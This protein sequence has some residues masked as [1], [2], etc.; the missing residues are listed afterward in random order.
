[1][2]NQQK[3]IASRTLISTVTSANS[4]KP[5]NR[6]KQGKLNKTKMLYPI[7]ILDKLGIKPGK[8]N[9]GGY[10]ILRCPYHKNGQEKKPSLHVHQI[11]G[12]FKCQSC[13]EKGDIIKLYMTLA[14]VTFCNAIRDLGAFWEVN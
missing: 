14:N 7:A 12:H 5:V 13:G 9:R 2:S 1:M 4:Y 6:N 8:A 10:W 11:D 3:D